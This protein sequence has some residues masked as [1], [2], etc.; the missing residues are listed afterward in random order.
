MYLP[1][2]NVVLSATY[3]YTINLALLRNN[4]EILVYK[5]ALKNPTS[6]K[7]NH[8]FEV[9]HDAIDRMVMQSDLRDIYHGVHVVGF[10]T[11]NNSIPATTTALSKE[12]DADV[13]IE[14]EFYLQL[15]DNSHDESQ[16]VNVF[17]RYLQHHNYS[18]GGTNIYSSKQFVNSLRASG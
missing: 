11:I 18:L 13:G 2:L 9:V 7:T 5:S 4:D 8:L 12:A 15:S 14:T 1:L 17:Q 10:S 16:L 6:P 3:S